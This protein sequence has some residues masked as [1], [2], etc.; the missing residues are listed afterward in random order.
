ML[1][2]EAPKKRESESSGPIYRTNGCNLEGCVREIEI[3][4]QTEIALVWAGGTLKASKTREEPGRNEKRPAVDLLTPGVKSFGRQSSDF[5]ASS[6]ERTLFI[7]ILCFSKG[8]AFARKQVIEFDA[9][10]E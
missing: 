10:G 4:L 5:D 7:T 3:S 9:D 2:L 1:T 6:P 8:V